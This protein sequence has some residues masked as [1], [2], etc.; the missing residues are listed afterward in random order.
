MLPLTPPTKQEG[1]LPLTAGWVN[2]QVAHKVS[3]DAV[4]SVWGAG[5]LTGD[6]DENSGSLLGLL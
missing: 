1:V 6:R 3:T 5:R 2:S 4:G